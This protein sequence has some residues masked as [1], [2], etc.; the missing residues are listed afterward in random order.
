MSAENWH[1]ERERL[2][3]LLTGLESGEITHIDNEGSYPLGRATPEK[4]AEV[5]KRLVTLNGR[6]GDG[7]A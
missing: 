6:L 2:V 1:E 5:R 7:G 3:Q 4:I